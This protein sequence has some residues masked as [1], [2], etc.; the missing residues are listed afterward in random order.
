MRTDMR[1]SYLSW[2]SAIWMVLGG[3]ESS[4]DS[5]GVVFHVSGVRAW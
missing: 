3:M 2:R 5:S 4:F 1:L